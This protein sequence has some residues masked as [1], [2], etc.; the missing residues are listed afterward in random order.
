MAWGCVIEGSHDAKGRVP[1]AIGILQN[2]VHQTITF[3][4]WTAAMLPLVVVLF[5]FC[6]FLLT[7]IFPIDIDTV[8]D[9]DAVINDQI[10]DCGRPLMEEKFLGLLIVGAI[11]S[12]IFIG[13]QLG[14]A[15]ISILAV[16]FLFM[17]RVVEWHDLQERMEWG[18]PDVW[19][20]DCDQQHPELDGGGEV[21]C[22]YLHSAASQLSLDVGARSFSA[23][24]RSYGG[25]E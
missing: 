4:Q 19:W 8:A 5:A 1:L 25:D 2:E 12:W 14:M 20:R 16:V 22:E 15:T 24:D 23:D 3:M 7:R 18:G 17:F 6:Y 13:P 11:L 9:A 10:R 21:V